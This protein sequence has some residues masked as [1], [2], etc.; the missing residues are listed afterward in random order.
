MAEVRFVHA[1][2][3]RRHALAA[4]ASHGLAIRVPSLIA[5]LNL[6]GGSDD[7]VK[8]FERASLDLPLATSVGTTAT[9]GAWTSLALGPDEWLLVGPEAQKTAVID[10]LTA[11]LQDDH[12]SI[13]DVSFNRVA[14]DIGG[15]NALQLLAALSP[16][17]S[18]AAAKPACAE[19]LMAKAQVVLQFPGGGA[20]FRV[21]V[22][23]S[24]AGYL[25]DVIADAA[26]F[27]SGGLP[28]DRLAG[29]SYR[30]GVASLESSP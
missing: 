3:S 29:R 19:T 12:A 8:G 18:A 20:D 6:R 28:A 30:R 24:F 7:L 4:L 1:L 26:P 10:G 5:Q 22:R 17:S 23:A 11:G 16:L 14:I 9:A 27:L 15:P 25:A 13:V 2:D 21:F